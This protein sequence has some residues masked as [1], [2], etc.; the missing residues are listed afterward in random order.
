MGRISIELVPRDEESL[1]RELHLARESFPS[2][3]TINIPDLLKFGVRS[4]EGCRKAKAY[5]SHAIPHLRAID[6]DLN[7]PF[8]LKEMLLQSGIEEV[9]VIAG[10]RPQDMSRRV[11][12]TSSVDLI[13]A[14][15]EQVPELKVFAGI[16]Q[17]RS[18]IKA[19]LDY[20]EEKLEAGADGFFTQ[21]FFDLRLMQIY[22]DLLKGLEVY[23]GASPVTSLRSK[24][25]WENLNKAVFPP[26][27]EPTLAWNRRFARE[28]LEFCDKTG[29]CIY[30]M[31]IRVDLVDYLSGIIR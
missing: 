2:V 28:A 8:P 14:I 23:W 10:D 26:D 18:G 7:K 17:Y 5:F 19:E 13:R 11:F 31:P 30:Y 3:D 22:H 24:D 9:L 20:V 25:Y 16:D 21:P 15:K 27:F 6:F 12:R 1:T 29:S 4:W